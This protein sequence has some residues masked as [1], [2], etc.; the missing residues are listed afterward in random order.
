MSKSKTGQAFMRCPCFFC[1]ILYGCSVILFRY[2][3]P[4]LL[5]RVLISEPDLFRRLG[6]RAERRDGVFE[7]QHLHIAVVGAVHAL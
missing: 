2:S 3:N 7:I 6:E 4:P 1:G 5:S